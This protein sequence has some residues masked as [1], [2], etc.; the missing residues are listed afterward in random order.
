MSTTPPDT[1]DNLVDLGTTPLRARPRGLGS[2]VAAGDSKKTKSSVKE[3]IREGPA[4]NI[5]IVFWGQFMAAIGDQGVRRDDIPAL[6]DI[7]FPRSLDDQEFSYGNVETQSQPVWQMRLATNIRENRIWKD[8]R[9]AFA[10]AQIEADLYH[11]LRSVL[12]LITT[13][14]RE[15]AEG[16]AASRTTKLTWVSNPDTPLILPPESDAPQSKPDIMGLFGRSVAV[17][18]R[19]MYWTS[20]PERWKGRIEAL[21]ILVPVEVEHTKLQPAATDEETDGDL[22]KLSH[23]TSPTSSVGVSAGRITASG[24]VVDR[25]PSITDRVQPGPIVDA[26]PLK[27]SIPKLFRQIPS[28]ALSVPKGKAI[29]MMAYLATV[30]E[31][32]PFRTGALG[33]IVQNDQFSLMYSDAAGTILTPPYPIFKHGDDSFLHTIIHLTLADYPQFGFDSLWV[34]PARTH[35]EPWDERVQ[36]EADPRFGRHRRISVEGKYYEVDRT[37]L[38]RYSVH[39]RST[40][41]ITIIPLRPSPSGDLVPASSV[42]V[43]KS[44][45]IVATRATERKHVLEGLKA[46]IRLMGLDSGQEDAMTFWTHRALALCQPLEIRQRRVL[47]MDRAGRMIGS[48]SDDKVVLRCFI[49]VMDGMST[50]HS[51]TKL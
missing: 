32:Q 18:G 26:A 51:F 46:G 29:T 11:P 3:G 4:G 34:H 21:D 12:D 25:F 45:W 9:D 5:G 6:A 2:F 20:S 1:S 33:I 7:Y 39:G 43:M 8:A 27:K 44:S 23:A 41:V 30:R 47:T 48:V 17:P 22:I 19:D 40:T 49:D 31:A 37:L 10:A 13:A 24:E 38:R 15:T 16:S 28:S 42:M 36:A 14:T 35:T 50:N